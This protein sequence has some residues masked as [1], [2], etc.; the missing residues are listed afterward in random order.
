[1]NCA[2]VICKVYH[3]GKF[4]YRCLWLLDGRE[5]DITCLFYDVIDFIESARQENG[6]VFIHCQQGVSRSSAM[7]IA[8]M[9]WKNGK[10]Y[11]STHSEVKKKRNVSNP[12]AGFVVQ[13]RGLCSMAHFSPSSLSEWAMQDRAMR[14][15][16]IKTH[17][18]YFEFCECTRACLLHLIRS[19]ISS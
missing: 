10:D 2:S 19:H 16:D 9:M 1:M 13:V 4:K 5:E 15:D 11:A 17:R 18:F 3:P 6:H 14:W 8:Y 7:T 12:N